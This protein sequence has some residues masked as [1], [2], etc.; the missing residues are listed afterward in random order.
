MRWRRAKLPHSLAAVLVFGALWCLLVAQL[1]QYWAVTPEY[2]FGWLV[3]VFCGYLIFLRWKSRPAIQSAKSG[4]PIAVF[5][6][7]GIA[8][9]PTWV[10]G[11]ANS[12]WRLTAWLLA[13][14]TVALSLCAIYLAGGVSWVRHFAFPVCLILTAVPWPTFVEETVTQE[15]TKISTALTVGL[16]NLF[17]VHAVQHG[18][19]IEL[20]SGLIGI[21]EACSGIR[22][23][24]AAFMMSLFLGELYRASALRRFAIVFGGAVIAFLCNAARTF[25]LTTMAARKGVDTMAVWHDPTG[26]VLAVICFLLIWGAA[27]II[28]GPLPALAPPVTTR[29]GRF[30]NRLTF[31]LGGW[32]LFTVMGTEIWYRTHDRAESV[33]WSVMWPVHK[34]QFVNIPISKSE[35]ESLMFD[36]GRGAEWRNS[37]GSR[38]VGYF[39]RWN[40]GPRWSRV[41]ARGHR[42][43]VC[44]PAAGYK[45]VGDYGVVS[46]QTQGLVIP[47]HAMAFDDGG[48]KEYVFFC[49][50]EDGG[51]TPRHPQLEDSWGQVTRLRSVLLG[52]RRL[53]QQ[54][55]EVAV[56]GYDSAEQ[57]EAAFRREIGKL[58]EIK[59]NGLVA[60]ALTQ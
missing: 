35:A 27:R 55:L 28:S 18:N 59:T 44:F 17:Q 48:N 49:L 33:R 39:F 36:E 41:L 24:Q 8:L 22:S 16:L 30:P 10:I 57:A 5:L 1:S 15:L 42:P 4:I 50:W 20:T 54:T 34:D 26:Y 3:P 2:S 60:D 46:V 13:G 47:F 32:L 38:W 11:Q 29:P 14:E 6:V 40:R 51:E 53:G 25:V 43:E 21:D 45:A 56:S 52:K 19:L 12:D 31:A 7:A 58:V 9:L 37:D 23:L